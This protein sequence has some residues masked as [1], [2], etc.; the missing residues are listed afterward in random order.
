[1]SRVATYPGRCSSAWCGWIPRWIVRLAWRCSGTCVV[2]WLTASGFCSSGFRS[3]SA[4]GQ[5]ANCRGC[6]EI[7]RRSPTLGLRAWR[8]WVAYVDILFVNLLKLC[9][10]IKLGDG[11][12]HHRSEIGQG[13]MEKIWMVNEQRNCRR[14]MFVTNEFFN[15]KTL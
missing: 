2:G 12:F 11:V 3:W 13:D 8:I 4:H 15:N 14:I 5:S 10:Y 9:S 7:T 6:L 1:M